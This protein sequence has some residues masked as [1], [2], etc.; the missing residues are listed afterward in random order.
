LK[1][2]SFDFNIIRNNDIVLFF[3]A[4]A[5]PD[6]CEKDFQSAYAVNVAGTSRFIKRFLEHNARI[7]FFSSDS[8]FHGGEKTF[9]ED[10]VKNPVGKYGEMKLSI[11]KEFEKEEN[12][13]IFRL[14]Y[15]YSKEDKFSSYLEGCSK[16]GCAVEVYPLSRNVVHLDDLVEGIDKL[17]EAWDSWNNQVFN[18]CGEDLISRA[19]IA[20]YFKENISAIEIK[21]VEPEEAFFKA[22][23]RAIEM[24]SKFFPALLGRQPTPIQRAMLKEYLGQN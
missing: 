18:I 6:E 23:P 19:D 1:S 12:I 13:K 8:V 14:S 15:I 7:L 21:L 2:Q 5:H 11:E 20:R 9:Y 17:I 10:S 24:K 4:T 3:A 22:R 16:K